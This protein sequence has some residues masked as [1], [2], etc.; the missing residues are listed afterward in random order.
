MNED[1]SLL[2]YTWIGGGLERHFGWTDVIGSSPIRFF[3]PDDIPRFAKE[4]KEAR[5]RQGARRQGAQAGGSP[6]THTLPPAAATGDLDATVEIYIPR[7]F[8]LPSGEYV[9]MLTSGAI[10]RDHWYTCCRDLSGQRRREEALRALLLSTS[11]ELREPANSVLV[12]TSLL[13]ALPVVT[14]DKEASFLVRAIASSGGCLMAVIRNVFSLKSIEAG[15]L[16]T[17][18]SAFDP[19]EAL[20]CVVNT[21]SFGKSVDVSVDAHSLPRSVTTDQ[22]FFAHIFQNLLSN[23]MR[24]EAGKGV[25]VSCRYVPSDSEGAAGALEGTAG[26]LEGAVTDK[27]ACCAQDAGWM[28]HLYPLTPNAQAAAWMR[29]HARACSGSTRRARPAAAASGSTSR[30]PAPSAWA[31]T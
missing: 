30:V 9:P 2:S 5:E 31:A 19:A 12:A 14:Q 18:L 29:N 22:G 1:C 3:H 20:R 10:D 26:M 13:Q 17:S 28:T 11:R 27:G 7:R 23:A 24:Y 15:E 25:R 4:L 21:C 16:L 8:L 6:L